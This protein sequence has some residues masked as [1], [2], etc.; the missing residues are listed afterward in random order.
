[1]TAPVWRERVLGRSRPDQAF[2]LALVVACVLFYVVGRRQWF[3]RDDWAFLLSRQRLRAANGIG[4]WLFTAQ[5]GHWMTP[6]LAFWR[7]LQNVFGVG[8]YWPYLLPT[9][10][11]HIAAVVL[12]RV[13]CRRLEVS[14][15]TTTILCTL[16]LVFGSGWENIVF[17]VQVVYNVSLVCFLAHLLLVDHDG[18]VDRRDVIGAA[19]GV[20][21]I[22][23]SGFGPFFLV[24]V[25]TVLVLRRR[26][27]AAA[28]ATVPQGVAYLWW[29]LAWGEDPTAERHTSTIGGF[30]RFAREELSLTLGS[31]TGQEVFGG[32][33]L[34]GI[35]AV[36]VWRRRLGWWPRTTLIGLVVTVA[37]M[38]LGIAYQR[39][40]LGLASASSSRYLYMGAM[41]LVPAIGIAVDQARHFDRYALLAVRL[42]LVLA[43]LQNA[44]ALVRWS[45]QWADRSRADQELFAM[46]AG[47]PGIEQADQR[48]FM[49]DY[50]PDVLLADLP[51]LVADGAITPRTGLTQA[52]QQIIVDIT[53]GKPVHRPVMP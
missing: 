41:L 12:V 26:W 11:L 35:V 49:S 2:R 47:W 45:D 52:E 18:P 33:A 38:F 22:T 20:L 40:G 34:L 6:P 43:T 44:R 31:I 16:L 13:W 48:L 9:I 24:G 17:A 7:V 15:W 10:A 53:N 4:A 30:L 50:N 29:W 46:V 8:S 28:I 42:L 21:S 25:G 39:A 51:Q 36:C 19:L 5:D 14:E 37:V 3:V 1:M 32:A 23:S 27:V